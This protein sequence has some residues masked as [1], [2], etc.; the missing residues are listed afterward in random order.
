MSAQNIL[1]KKMIDGMTENI[2]KAMH[3]KY[4]SKNFK[5]KFT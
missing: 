5:L 4:S 3:E 2:N 1:N